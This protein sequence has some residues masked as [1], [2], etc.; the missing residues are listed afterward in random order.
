MVRR[1]PF[2]PSSRGPRLKILLLAVLALALVSALGFVAAG[3]DNPADGATTGSGPFPGLFP[4]LSPKP[5]PTGTA[6]AQVDRKAVVHPDGLLFG[7]ST[8]KGPNQAETDEVAAAAGQRP[9]V[10]EYFVKWNEEFDPDTV[11]RSYELGAVPL[12][13]WEPWAGGD[14]DTDQPQYALR[15]ITSGAHDG[16]LTRFARSVK[17]QGQPVVLRF[18]HE[19]NADWYPW[20]EGRN[21][22]RTGDYVAAWRHVHDLFRDEGVTNVVWFWC[23]DAVGDSKADPAGY[24]PG[25][26][27]VDWI[28]A[29][30]YSTGEESAERTLQATYDALAAIADKPIFIGE[31]SVKPGQHRTD[32]TSELFTWLRSHP[33][34]IGFCWF[35]H[36]KEGRGRYD[37]RFTTSADSQRAFSAGLATQRLADWPLRAAS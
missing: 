33:K 26:D 35:Q 25:H 6:V 20:A 15:R 14:Q 21:G 36:N 22:N 29:D 8:P 24:Y 19:M 1:F 16:Y 2:G 7:I 32:W 5:A 17:A 13:T 23:P 4:S 37:W 18:A 28:G 30:A 10:Q 27:Y 34:V 3:S 9:T 12:L 31:T 11:E